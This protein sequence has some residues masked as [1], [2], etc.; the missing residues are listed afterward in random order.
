MLSD[1]ILVLMMHRSKMCA[2]EWTDAEIAAMIDQ[3]MMPR[4]RS[5]G[6]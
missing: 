4:L 1:V 5:P 2:S 6:A 3:I